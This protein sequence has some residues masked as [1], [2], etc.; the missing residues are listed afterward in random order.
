MGTRTTQLNL[1]FGA[2][3][4]PKS[5]TKS[6]SV[7]CLECDLPIDLASQA[8]REIRACPHCGDR[9]WLLLLTTKEASILYGI[10]TKDLGGRLRDGD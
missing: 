5:K 4:S 6:H 7:Q 3:G 2:I 10:A 1:D 8:A 9:D